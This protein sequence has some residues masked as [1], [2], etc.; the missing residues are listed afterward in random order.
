[1]RLGLRHSH[2]EGDPCTAFRGSPQ[3]EERQPR[4]RHERAQIFHIFGQILSLHH[5]KVSLLTGHASGLS[6]RVGRLVRGTQ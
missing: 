6:K 4:I 1:M 3:I 5:Q 2:R